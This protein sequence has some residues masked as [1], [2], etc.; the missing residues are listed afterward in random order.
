MGYTEEFYVEYDLTDIETSLKE[1]A[2]TGKPTKLM[3]MMEDDLVAQYVHGAVDIELRFG[4]ED[5]YPNELYVAIY[6]ECKEEGNWI[7]TS[8]HP[9]IEFT[10]DKNLLKK[11]MK[12]VADDLINSKK[13][14]LDRNK[15]IV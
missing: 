11:R 9:A 5:Y 7:I 12:K 4:K 15:N 6:L 8:H 3:Y 1:Y 2:K 13:A 10:A 14:Y